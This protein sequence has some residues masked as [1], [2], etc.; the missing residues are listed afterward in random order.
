MEWPNFYF[1]SQHLL[2][3][4]SKPLTLD[5]FFRRTCY[6]W[7][8]FY[9]IMKRIKVLGNLQ[10]LKS[11]SVHF[12]YMIH[13]KKLR[14]LQKSSKVSMR[15]KVSG[16]Y[17]ISGLFMRQMELW[18]MD[19]KMR[20]FLASYGGVAWWQSIRLDFSH[21]DNF[22][23]YPFRSKTDSEDYFSLFQPYVECLWPSWTTTCS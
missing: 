20:I 2:Y 18:T 12:S 23:V 15:S 6:N 1:Y 19:T 8:A 9:R 16:F 22:H 14:N 17:G 5:L 4:P 13:P 10:I 11:G 21:G 7:N 3:I